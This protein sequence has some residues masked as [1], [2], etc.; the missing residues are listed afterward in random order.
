[1]NVVPTAFKENTSNKGPAA[2]AGAAHGNTEADGQ[3]IAQGH[4]DLEIF[5]MEKK[6]TR[7]VDETRAL[8]ETYSDVEEKALAEL[9]NGV[10][11]RGET[12]RRLGVEEADEAQADSGRRCEVVRTLLLQTPAHT[13]EGVAVKLR[14]LASEYEVHDQNLAAIFRTL[15]ADAERADAST[16]AALPVAAGRLTGDA[17][18]VEAWNKF[19][20]AEAAYDEA[21][22]GLSAE[23]A[24]AWRDAHVVPLEEM[25]VTMPAR[26]LP[27]IAVKLRFWGHAAER[28]GSMADDPPGLAAR[29]LLSA[30]QD[31]E[32]ITNINPL[33]GDDEKIREAFAKFLELEAQYNAMPEDDDAW[34]DAN[35]APLEKII[36]DTPASGLTGLTVKL[37][38]WRNQEDA[39]REYADSSYTPQRAVLS[40]CKD[41][42][43]L[44]A[45]VTHLVW[46]TPGAVL[47][48]MP[49]PREREAAS[50]DR[51]ASRKASAAC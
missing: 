51:G 25:I 12:Y 27:G 9:K 32:F 49:E 16:I 50:G 21:T 11:D 22:R 8:L 15:A 17:A 43:Y 34:Y 30:I 46:Q 6:L 38:F 20:R 47:R 13:A 44:A 1:M 42:D 31:A 39:D 33:P 19:L 5:A 10:G 28:P 40:A 3:T 4:P 37:R 29:A 48:K 14:A 7:L 41:A 2:P 36:V 35:I 23:D 26:Y 18:L 24:Q 45:Y